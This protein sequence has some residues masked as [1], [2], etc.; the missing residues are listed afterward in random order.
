MVGGRAGI[1]RGVGYDGISEKN[2]R[3]LARERGRPPRREEERETREARNGW[4]GV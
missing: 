1:S 3:A 4:R 2:S